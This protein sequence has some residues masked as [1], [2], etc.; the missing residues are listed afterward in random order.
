MVY[1]PGPPM[2][3]LAISRDLV[4]ADTV[5]HKGT[6][7]AVAVLRPLYERAGLTVAVQ[8]IVRNGAHHQNLLGTLPGADPAGL[9][10]AT[11]LDTVDPGPAELWTETDN[12]PLWLTQ[13]GDELY[14]LGAA[15]AKLAA[16]CQLFAARDFQGR[17]L[18]RALQL[19]GTYGAEA[20]CEGTRSFLQS[21][22]RRARFAVLSEPTELH[23]VPAHKGYAAIG[24]EL[25]LPDTPELP[26]PHERLVFEA[27]SI[28]SAL[29]DGTAHAI[30]RALRVC[31]G[32]PVVSLESSAAPHRLPSSATVVRPVGPKGMEG[33]PASP[34]DTRD[35]C[36]TVALAARLFA[37]WRAHVEALEPRRHEAFG[38]ERALVAWTAARVSGPRAELVF[39]ARLLPGQEP[40]T[41]T[42]AFCRE[43]ERLGQAA[44]AR[45]RAT[46]LQSKPALEL[47][48]EAELLASAQAACR[49]VGLD[50]APQ[51]HPGTTEAGFF[52]KVGLEALAFGPGRFADNAHGP[53]ESNQLS[54]MEK[55]IELYRALITRVCV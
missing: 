22:E 3:L 15:D 48:A 52:A 7:A 28:C 26:G 45:I 49:E 55:A 39:E 25:V 44:R 13:K 31:E 23:L 34:P 16:V 36:A 20:G 17:P 42:T 47:P 9:V 5:S 6:A 53:N 37:L 51:A 27:P 8:E 50:D 30:E 24:L 19:L 14:G 29:P 54:Q 12:T 40:D 1:R 4:A 35:A 41:L 10:L 43:A 21:P 11:H 46:V 2:D 33:V 32:A 18:R 38:A